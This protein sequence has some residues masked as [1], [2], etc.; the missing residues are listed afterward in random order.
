MDA[1]YDLVVVG[2][3][4][5]GM[6][7]GGL[8]ASCGLKVLVIEKNK[9]VGKKLL[10]TGKGRCN[11]TNAC[12]NEEFMESVATNKRFMYS[13]INKF[14]TQ[15]T[16]DFFNNLGVETK[17]ERGKRVFPLSDKS[18][19]VVDALFNFMQKSNCKLL[20]GN[21]KDIIISDSGTKKVVLESDKVIACKNLLLACGG[22]SYPK[23]GSDGSGF[24]LAKKLGHNIIEPKPSLISL[25]S[26]DSV[27]Q[28]LQG[29]SLRNVSIKVFNSS[30][31]KVIFS[32][33]GEM[34]FT[35]YGLSGPIIL[36]AS[37]H[38]KNPESIK[39]YIIIDLKPA[40]SFDQLD[41]RI[42]RE[43]SQNINKEF[44]NSLGNLLPK[45]LIPVII[46]LSGISPHY[47]CNQI[48]KSQRKVLVE[49]LKGFRINISKF[50]PIE[51]AIITCGGVDTREIN[52]KTMQSKLVDGIFF[53]G[54]IIDVDAYTGGFNLQIAFSTAY[55]AY[56]AITNN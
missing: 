12:S 39:H 33:F 34:I 52:P 36:S 41:R 13:A 18:S 47:K 15:D 56:L 43:L 5:A 14:S 29:L 45:K 28:R 4:P 2:A 25:V 26:N 9:K 11:L 44:Q 19:Q 54:E 42:Q 10:I 48:T 24:K 30:N 21:V 50:R 27:C 1:K 49:L 51:E 6:L 16:I 37:S 3:G 31:K 53:A 40:L 55:T 32:D 8:V 7:A 38:I 35:H 46:D 22:M 17:I 20:H 23:T